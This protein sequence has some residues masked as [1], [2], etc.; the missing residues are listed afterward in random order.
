MNKET[1][2]AAI[3]NVAEDLCALSQEEFAKE[4]EAHRDGDIAKILL[5]TKALDVGE[6]EAELFDRYFVPYAEEK[7]IGLCNLRPGRSASYVMGHHALQN[8]M[9]TVVLISAA[10]PARSF[11]EL[12]MEWSSKVATVRLQKP[13]QMSFFAQGMPGYE[14]TKVE[15][16][17]IAML[18]LTDHLYVAVL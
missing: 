15:S 7:H 4:L 5:E 9:Q 13:V 12:L 16:Y 8:L 14:M 6:I 10:I 18:K 11:A 17:N 2:Y 1:F 3:K